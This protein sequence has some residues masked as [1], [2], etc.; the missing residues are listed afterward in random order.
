VTR[1][2]FKFVEGTNAGK[3]PSPESPSSSTRSAKEMRPE[4]QRD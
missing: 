2:K 3:G 4:A 1:F